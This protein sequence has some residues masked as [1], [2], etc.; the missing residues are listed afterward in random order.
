MSHLRAY[1][2]KPSTFPPTDESS[3]RDRSLGPVLVGLRLTLNEKAGRPSTAG[4]GRD[5]P[6]ATSPAGSPTKANVIAILHRLFLFHSRQASSCMAVRLSSSFLSE[7]PLAFGC[8]PAPASSHFVES[9]GRRRKGRGA[10]EDQPH[11]GFLSLFPPAPPPRGP[12]AA[13]PGPEP[14]GRRGS[15]DRRRAGA[16]AFPPSRSPSP[17]RGSAAIG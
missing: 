15:T 7:A 9:R 1:P 5:N 4:P 10:P 17:A 8:S 12:Q 16:P 3:N 14:H 11:V 6:G 13:R 2:R